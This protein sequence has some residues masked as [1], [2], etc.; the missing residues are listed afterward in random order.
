MRV[1][2]CLI[3]FVVILIAACA[4]LSVIN[5]TDKLRNALN[6]YGT[7]LRWGSY[8]HAYAFHFDQEGNRPVVDMNALEKFSVTD[9]RPVDPVVN[10]DGTAATVP[11]EIDYYDE[12]Y[13]TLKK[14]KYVQNWWFNTEI[15]RWLTSS[16]F[17]VFE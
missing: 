17:P 16:D 10:E 13:G 6:D 4:N 3:V 2:K 5:Q 1:L 11:V 15:K 14:F 8:N 12:Q 7:A 9:F